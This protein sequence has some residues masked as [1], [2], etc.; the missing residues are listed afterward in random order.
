MEQD[1]SRMKRIV[2]RINGGENVR[3]L[4]CG[5]RIVAAFLYN[6]MDW[7][8]HEYS[9]PVDALARLGDDWLKKMLAYRDQVNWQ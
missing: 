2:E 9:H 8:P 1:V 4:S 5:E 7:L 3:V 6:R